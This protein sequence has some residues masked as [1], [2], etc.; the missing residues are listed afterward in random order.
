MRTRD[1]GVCLFALL[2]PTLVPGCIVAP[3]PDDEDAAGD[4]DEDAD[5]A[6]SQGSESSGSSDG[7]DG[8]DSGDDSDTADG[9]DSGDDP[10]DPGD[11]AGTGSDDSGGTDTGNPI[12]APQEGNWIFAETGAVTNDCNFIEEPTNGFGEYLLALTGDGFTITPGDQTDPFECEQDG[13]EFFCAERLN[14][15]L[16]AATATAYVYV[17]VEGVLDSSTSMSGSQ[18]GRIECEGDC[19][20]AEAVLDTTFPCTFEI[21]FTGTKL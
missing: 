19:A 21:G 20:T 13:V 10:D 14:E 16:A 15:T 4:T 17:S 18:I 9:D 5:S 12:D 1:F 2:L 11:S 7:S 8:S 6:S 3:A